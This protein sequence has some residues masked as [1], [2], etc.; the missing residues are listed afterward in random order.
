MRPEMREKKKKIAKKGLL[1][2]VLGFCV[3]GIR[4]GGERERESE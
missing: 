3:R 2:L 1:P 4:L